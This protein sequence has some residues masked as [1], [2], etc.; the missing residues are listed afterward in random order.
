[1][2]EEHQNTDGPYPDHTQE[3]F[4][5]LVQAGSQ[6]EVSSEADLLQGSL[7][8]GT[9]AEAV[10]TD[11]AETAEAE[12]LEAT[13][14]ILSDLHCHTASQNIFVV[15]VFPAL[16]EVL[17]VLCVPQTSLKTAWPIYTILHYC[18]LSIACLHHSG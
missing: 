1:M 17:A 15:L 11:E 16:A 2:A 5:C 12:L 18:G 6:L 9:T 8:P 7:S 10:V 13:A 4:P 14:L 3:M